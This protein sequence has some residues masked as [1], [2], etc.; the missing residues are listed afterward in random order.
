MNIVNDP[1]LNI[2]ASPR[3]AEGGN[4]MECVS[5]P[6]KAFIA[7]ANFVVKHNTKQGAVRYG[8][9]LFLFNM[10][11]ENNIKLSCLCC[12]LL[13]VPYEYYLISAWL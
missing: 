3:P 7:A 8:L 13:F 1:N 10:T 6:C 2:K 11:D 5:V 12:F 9:P 4:I